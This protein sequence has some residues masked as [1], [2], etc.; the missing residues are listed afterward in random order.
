MADPADIQQRIN[1]VPV[2]CAKHPDK[3]ETTDPNYHV[4]TIETRLCRF[5][6]GGCTKEMALRFFEEALRF[7]YPF[8]DKENPVQDC[9]QYFIDAKYGKDPIYVAIDRTSLE[10]KNIT[11]PGHRFHPGVVLRKVVVRDNGIWIV[12]KGEGMGG[13]QFLNYWAGEAGFRDLDKKL[14]AHLHK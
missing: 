6:P 1:S 3:Y 10:A 14:Y 13:S 8:Q 4:Y 9:G 2:D 7:Q 12:T 11:Q 5:S